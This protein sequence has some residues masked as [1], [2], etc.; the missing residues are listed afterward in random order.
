MNVWVLVVNG[1]P[2]SVHIAGSSTMAERLRLLK[3]V[4]GDAFAYYSQEF[5][6]KGSEK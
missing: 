6:V 5:T 4:N 1:K 2:D 3:E